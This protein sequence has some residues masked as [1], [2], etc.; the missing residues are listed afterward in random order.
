MYA[1]FYSKY[2]S[3]SVHCCTKCFL[4]DKITFIVLSSDAVSSVCPSLEKSIL[5]TVAVCALNTVDSP[6]LQIYTKLS[7]SK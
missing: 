3:L 6:L 1:Q 2:T 5:L 4:N 7:H